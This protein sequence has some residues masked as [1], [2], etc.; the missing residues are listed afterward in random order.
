MVGDSQAKEDGRGTARLGEVCRE[1]IQ[2][3]EWGYSEYI[4]GEGSIQSG[5]YRGGIQLQEGCRK[6][7]ISTS[8]IF[9][10]GSWDLPHSLL[11]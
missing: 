1:F 2:P 5:W 6:V 10:G 3:L 11:S 9:W 7:V 8:T 4:L